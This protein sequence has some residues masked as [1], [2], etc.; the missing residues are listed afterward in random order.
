MTT[1]RIAFRD[2]TAIEQEEPP[3]VALVI[4]DGRTFAIGEAFAR[5]LAERA[6]LAQ[7]LDRARTE[8]ADLRSAGA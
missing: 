5:L 7:E 8:L 6:H 4:L 2:G 3:L 1:H